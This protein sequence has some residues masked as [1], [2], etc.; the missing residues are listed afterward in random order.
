MRTVADL[1]EFGLIDRIARRTGVAPARGVTLGIGDDAALLRVRKGFELAVSTDTLVEDVHFR[2][3]NQAPRTLGRRAL[4]INL[5]DLAAMGARPLAFTL[6]L[7]LPA[8]LPIP[9]V[10]G[11][12][13]GL[14]FE[15]RAFEIPWVGGNV[16]RA[17]ELSLSITVM[18]E[19]ERGRALRRDGLAVGDRLFVTG[20]LGGAALALARAER[21]LARLTR[22]PEPRIAAGRALLRG[23]ICS[24][25]LDLSDGLAGDLRHLTRAS[26]VGAEIEL[27]RL[28]LARGLERGAAALGLDAQAMAVRG[29]EDYELLFGVGAARRVT[30]RGLTRSLGTAVT[31]IGHVT[32]TG[33]IAGLG[34]ARGH[35]HF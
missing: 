1:G 30:E 25:C 26:G 21:G 28:P 18:G 35:R 5:S 29:G 15:S 17:R 22:L 24:A 19:V 3:A 9:I 8:D 2:L 33:R 23:G 32:G 12:V 34:S 27:S 7:A 13:A 20:A 10:D 16:T 14:V 11:L 6:A 4:R 31:E